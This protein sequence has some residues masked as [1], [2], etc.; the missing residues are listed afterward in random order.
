MPWRNDG[1]GQDAKYLLEIT[2]CDEARSE[3]SLP[4]G[5]D[6]MEIMRQ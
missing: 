1:V 6:Q 3:L 2:N 4:V 5:Q